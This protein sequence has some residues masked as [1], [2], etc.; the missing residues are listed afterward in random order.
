[1]KQ[2]GGVSACTFG[3]DAPK[4]AQKAAHVDADFEAFI[5][6][7]GLIDPAAEVARLEKQIAEKTKFLEATKAKLANEGFVARA[8]AEVVQQQRE[9]VAELEGQIAAMKTNLAELRA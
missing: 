1:M 3:P 4:P 5:S 8:P 2:L 9:S 7:V 6:L